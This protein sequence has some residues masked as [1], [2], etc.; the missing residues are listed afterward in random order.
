M[1][2][3]ILDLFKDKKIKSIPDYVLG[4]E[5]GLDSNGR[6]NRSGTTMQNISEDIIKSI[7]KANNFEYL[8]Q[9]NANKIKQYFG[10]NIKI[11]KSIRSFDF[12]IKNEDKLYIIETNYYGGGGSKL[13]ATA[14]EYAMLYNDL[15]DQGYNFIWITEGLGWT[16]TQKPLK[17]TFDKIDYLFNLKMV[18]SGLFADIIKNKL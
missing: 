15:K 6:K 12:A 4:I 16:T 17:E 5:V 3:G 9:A 11:D 18:S 7:C 8:A 10:F 13:K 2:T 14:G 1:K